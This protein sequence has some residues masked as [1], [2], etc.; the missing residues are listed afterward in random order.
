M[1]AW[2]RVLVSSSSARMCSYI[3]LSVLFARFVGLAY[4]LPR[5]AVV[6]IAAAL[7]LLS[8]ALLCFSMQARGLGLA[9]AFYDNA[10]S[11][12]RVAAVGVSLVAMGFL[13]GYVKQIVGTSGFAFSDGTVRNAVIL[14]VCLLLVVGLIFRRAD[15][16][17]VD[18]Y[19]AVMYLLI[20][21][22][23]FSAFAAP[24]CLAVSESAI[25]L[26]QF[27]LMGLVWIVSP[28]IHVRVLGKTVY[29]FGW[30]FFAFY[31]SS[32]FG[33]IACSALLASRPFGSAVVASHCLLLVAL[34]VHFFLFREQDVRVLVD[35]HENAQ[36]ARFAMLLERGAEAFCLSAREREV[37]FL[38]LQ[39]QSAAEVSESLGV[40]ESTVRSH[41]QHIY[42]K[43]GAHSR[44]SLL[45]IVRMA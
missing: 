39:G 26:S 23:A 6:S 8:A 11:R 22:C 42:T 3:L 1:L 44:E 18:T 32:T 41:V 16:L 28:V 33:S 12:G 21:G 14:C 27:M 40:S 9:E 25:L 36:R 15:G 24:I 30:S 31:A 38:W 29:L 7:P 4:A 45:E 20:A 37:A 19:R 17:F 13:I 5:F 34:T 35:A 2:C 43:T 10:L